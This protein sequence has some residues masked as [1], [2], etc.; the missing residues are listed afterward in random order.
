MAS[1]ADKKPIRV[2]FIAGSLFFWL[3]GFGVGLYIAYGKE[4]A[5]RHDFEVRT[6]KIAL[7][8]AAKASV[9]GDADAVRHLHALSS[10]VM[11]PRLAKAAERELA[12]L[13]ERAAREKTYISPAVIKALTEAETRP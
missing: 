3:F 2:G 9:K 7:E 1:R 8:F 5:V 6:S 13:R 10:Q 11:L 4:A 12:L